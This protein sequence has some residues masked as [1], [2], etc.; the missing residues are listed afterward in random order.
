MI[1][2]EIPEIVTKTQKFIGLQEALREFMKSRKLT[3][4]ETAEILG[5][6]RASVA[7]MVTGK[8]AI[9]IE[10]LEKLAEHFG[11]SIKLEFVFAK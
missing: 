3:Q 8:Q 6:S 2:I 10:Y 1:T 4:I 11:M 5:I 9:S 7:N